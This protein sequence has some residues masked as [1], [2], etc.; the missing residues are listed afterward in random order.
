MPTMER[1]ARQVRHVH[2]SGCCRVRIV[3]NATARLAITTGDASGHDEVTTRYE[4]DTLVIRSL[5]PG[6][7]VPRF[8]NVVIPGSGYIVTGD[9]ISITG[10]LL[11]GRLISTGTDRMGITPFVDIALQTVNRIRLAGPGEVLLQ[12]LDQRELDIR[13]T[14]SGHIVAD[15]RIGYLRVAID[16]SGNVDASC[17]RAWGVALHLAGSGNVRVHATGAAMTRANGPGNVVIFGHP[18]LRDGRVSGGG[19]IHYR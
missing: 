3:R 1:E 18:P 10:S 7:A 6:I 17:L 9:D 16:G 8:G 12:G 14:G 4:D 15:G 11:D 13:L 19:D 5:H 2:V